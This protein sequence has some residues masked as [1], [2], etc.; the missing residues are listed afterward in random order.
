WSSL[1]GHKWSSL[2]W[3]SGVD[4]NLPANELVERSAY[5]YSMWSHRRNQV[6]KGYLEVDLNPAHDQQA[7]DYLNQQDALGAQ[8]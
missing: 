1:T 6:W 5:W 8:P 2:G 4:L 7:T 3:P